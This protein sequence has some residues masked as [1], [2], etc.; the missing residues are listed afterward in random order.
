MM[1]KND[2]LQQP[3]VAY[4]NQ[5]ILRENE[6][7]ANQ[8]AARCLQV[9]VFVVGMEGMRYH[10]GTMTLNVGDKLFQYTDG[11]TE[12]TNANQELY[13]MERLGQ[14]LNQHSGSIPAH[15]LVEVRKDIDRFVGDAPQFDDITM[16]C[17][18]YKGRSE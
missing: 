12:A 10:T 6:K 3:E 17:L 9:M 2:P 7:E 13:G 8:Y 15:I 18:E 16:L 1:K 5:L 11:V 14:V 4:D